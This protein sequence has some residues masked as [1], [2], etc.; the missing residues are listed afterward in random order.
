MYILKDV[1]KFRRFTRATHTVIF[2]IVPKSKK[3]CIRS[4]EAK[5]SNIIESDIGNNIATE[6]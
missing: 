4:T 1:L 5:D 6:A 3:C 2:K